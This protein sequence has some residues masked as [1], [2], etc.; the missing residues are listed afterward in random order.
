MNNIENGIKDVDDTIGELKENFTNI[1]EEVSAIKTELGM[2]GG[3]IFVEL[4]DGYKSANF[5][6]GSGT[7]QMKYVNDALYIKKEV[8]SAGS[9]SNDEISISLPGL[10]PGQT[11]AYT[12]DKT[13]SPKLKFSY[14]NSFAD[15]VLELIFRFY[16][17]D[18]SYLNQA[19]YKLL[20]GSNEV[21]LDLVEFAES[22]NVNLDI[23][24]NLVF[25]SLGIASHTADSAEIAEIN[26]QGFLESGEEE[27][28]SDKVASNS[29]EINA[30][31]EDIADVESEIGTLSSTVGTYREDIDTCKDELGINSSFVIPDGYK[32]ASYQNAAGTLKFKYEN[33]T[34]VLR[35]ANGSSGEISTTNAGLTIGATLGYTVSA[36]TSVWFEYDYENSYQSEGQAHLVARYYNDAYTNNRGVWISLPIGSGTVKIDLVKLAADNSIDLST[37]K[38]FMIRSL[39]I[40]EGTYDGCDAV[41]TIHGFRSGSTL[42]ETV[43]QQASAI[44]TVADD[45]SAVQADV[46]QNA[47]DIS[48]IQTSIGD[49]SAKSSI[50]GNVFAYNPW[51]AHLFLN[52]VTD[53]AENTYIPSQSLYD[54]EISKRLGFYV[55][56]ANTHRTSDGKFVC[57]HG[58]NNTFASEFVAAEGSSY[59]DAQIQETNVGEV[60]LD[61]IR[62]NVRYKAKYPKMRVSPPTLEEFLY[63]CKKNVMVP[64]I[65]YVHLD[66]I[67]I[68]DRIMGKDNYIL[69]SAPKSVRKYSNAPFLTITRFMTKEDVVNWIHDIGTPCIWSALHPEDHTKAE[70]AEVVDAVHEAGALINFAG[71]YLTPEQTQ[72]WLDIGFDFGSS[73]WDLNPIVSGNMANLNGDATFSDFTTTGTVNDGTIE[74]DTNETIVPATTLASSF[75]CG[76]WLDITF[77]GEISVSMGRWLTH[78]GASVFD[79]DTPRTIHLSTYWLNTAPTFEI[80]SLSNGTVIESLVFKASKM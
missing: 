72:E 46:S 41:V 56:E 30:L 45:L 21:T 33:G 40:E 53:S 15:N 69:Y 37:F 35:K 51:C 52:T 32:S 67:G 18:F 58:S 2:S 68:A 7:R 59:T 74:L 34:L 22:Y 63:A 38:N 57:F 78:G 20:N 49:M 31:K 79:A 80:K 9:V 12:V 29:T 76:S 36:D 6:N 27:K 65:N 28:L 3:N 77:T 44:A 48:D 50:A 66:E 13:V 8:T 60:T 42:K 64:L 17:A 61:W 4:P 19:Q 47:N 73:G 26:L 23:Y 14:T 16:N 5:S 10:S 25:R 1:D 70:W 71:G 43:E 11:T 24:N 39:G 75:L 55:I 62:T 54:I